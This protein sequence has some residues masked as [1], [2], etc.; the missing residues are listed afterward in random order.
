MTVPNISS[1]ADLQSDFLNLLI[2]QLQNQNPLDP[3]NTNDMSGQ[4]AQFS[5]LEQLENMNSRFG[6][7]LGTLQKNY[8]TNLVGKEVSYA[9]SDDENNNNVASG[10]VS[11]VSVGNDDISLLVGNQQ[12]SLADILSIGD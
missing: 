4:L 10:T 7:V 6:D 5:Q 9:T 12:I 11:G 2:T 8:A 1:S 3:M